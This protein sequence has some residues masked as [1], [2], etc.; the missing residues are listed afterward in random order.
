MF[1]THEKNGW[2]LHI[3]GSYYNGSYLI[4]NTEVMVPVVNNLHAIF[5]C[6]EYI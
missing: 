4:G 3:Y 1:L 5:V 6:F 2:I